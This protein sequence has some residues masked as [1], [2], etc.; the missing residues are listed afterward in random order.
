MLSVI[1]PNVV[2]DLN[3]KQSLFLYKIDFVVSHSLVKLTTMELENFLNSF[4][5]PGYFGSGMKQPLDFGSG[6][7]GISIAY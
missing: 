4:S 1:L 5:A 3:Y 7:G 2:V 6:F